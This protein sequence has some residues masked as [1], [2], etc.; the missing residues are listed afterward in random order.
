MS[1]RES[2]ISTKDVDS[3]PDELTRGR[4]SRISAFPVGC[5]VVVRID[6]YEKVL[7]VDDA[8]SLA[9]VLAIVADDVRLKESEEGRANE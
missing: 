7:S 8:L 3:M 1:A 5:D 4:C 6:S 9:S 2:S